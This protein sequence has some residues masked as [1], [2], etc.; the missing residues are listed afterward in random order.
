MQGQ[1]IDERVT[2]QVIGRLGLANEA[3][4]VVEVDR[5]PRV[6]VGPVG[7]M[8]TTQLVDH[9]V[10]LDGVDMARARASAAATSLP[11]PAPMISTSLKRLAARVTVQ[12]VRQ[13]IARPAR[14]DRQHPLV[15]R[16]C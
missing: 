5:D 3:A 4:A 15:R 11:E 1:R 2:D 7:M 9:R 12:Q 10:D 8:E 6:A 14:V 13:E 16:C